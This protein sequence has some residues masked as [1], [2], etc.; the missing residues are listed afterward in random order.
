MKLLRY[1][2]IAACT[3]LLLA[4]FLFFRTLGIFLLLVVLSLTFIAVRGAPEVVAAR[5]A[6]ELA[7]Q[8][9]DAGDP[10]SFKVRRGRI[11]GSFVFVLGEG[12][13]RVHERQSKRAREERG[14]DCECVNAYSPVSGTVLQ[15]LKESE[16]VVASGT[17]LVE[18]GDPGRLEIVVDLLSTDAVR[19]EAGQRALIEAWGGDVPL[20]GVVSYLRDR[21]E[22]PL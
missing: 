12:G 19:V 10:N 4:S 3:L 14:E 1:A 6:L 15:V 11:G 5:T 18:V 17:P 16:G 20:E 2:T 7:E 8:T 13:R 22:A 9:A 21:V